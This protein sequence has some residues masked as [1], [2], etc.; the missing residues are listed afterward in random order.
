MEEKGVSGSLIVISEKNSDR[1]YPMFIGVSCAL[2]VLRLLPEPEIC[3][4]KWSEIRNGMLKGSALVGLLVSTVEKSKLLEKLENAEM[5]IAELKKRR[6][7]DAKANEKVVSIF[8]AREQSWFDERRKLSHQIFS[9]M[10]DLKVVEAKR[11][12]S[13]S[14]LGDKM[15][16]IEVILQLKDT[17]I[18]EAER[19]RL[20]S[21]EK[22]KEAHHLAEELRESHSSEISKHKTAFIEQVE[23]AKQEV[24]ALLEH[25][26]QLLLVNQM[27]LKQVRSSKLKRKQAEVEA[28]RW[29]AVAE[30]KHDRNS[31]LNAKSDGGEMYA[32]MEQLR[33]KDEKLEAYNWRLMISELESRRLKLRVEALDRDIAKLRQ[34]NAKLSEMMRPH[35]GD[36]NDTVWS[37]VKVVKLKAG[38]TRQEMM[39][40]VDEASEKDVVFTLQQP[41]IREADEVA[42]AQTSSNNCTWKM[43]VH[44]L[45]VSYKVKRLRQQLLVLERLPGK[46]DAESNA[47]VKGFYALMSLLNKQLDRYNSLQGKIDQ[48]YKRMQENKVNTKCEEDETKRMEQFLEETF[49]L[50]R[51]TVATGQKLME[52]QSM[53]ASNLVAEAEDIEKHG[54][55]DIERFAESLKTLFRETQ[56][57]LELRISR[58]IGDLEGTLAR[59]GFNT[60]R[61]R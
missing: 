4:E 11:E 39:K 3:D 46:E 47:R 43:D 53:I 33:Q 50:Q 36:G 49:Q 57:G 51:Y 59:D 21:E 41:H 35:E 6:S 13:V 1:L 38:H 22:L 55:F 12:N 19:R 15:K 31:F 5:E 16:E 52:V 8:A 18:E 60:W 30:S 28:A 23:A 61:K 42:A 26:E 7:E 10:N 58:I 56:R 44:A 34:D 17:M 27:L 14:E 20:E 40:K 45:G 24:E 9:L 32:Y 37:R 29:K 54:S 2:F 48:L 25:K